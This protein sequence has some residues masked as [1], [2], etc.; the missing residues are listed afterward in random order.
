MLRLNLTQHMRRTLEEFLACLDMD[1]AALT[2]CERNRLE[3]HEV[4]VCKTRVQ[5][6]QKD[7]RGQTLVK[8]TCK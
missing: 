7:R 2:V 3:I 1:R 6:L 5:V 8:E 4:T